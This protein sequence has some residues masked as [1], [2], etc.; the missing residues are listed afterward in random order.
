MWAKENAQHESEG[1]PDPLAEFT[2]PRERDFIRARYKFG[3]KTKE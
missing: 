1:L 3:K 2:D